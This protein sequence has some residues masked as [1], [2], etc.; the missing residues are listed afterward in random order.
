MGRLVEK[1]TSL[2]PFFLL[3]Q[4]FIR[5]SAIFS[6][7]PPHSLTPLSLYLLLFITWGE[8]WN[9]DCSLVPLMWVGPNLIIP[10]KEYASL[11]MR[12][13]ILELVLATENCSARQSPK[14]L[15]LSR[16]SQVLL[17]YQSTTVYPR[18]TW[19]VLV[20]WDYEQ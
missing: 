16:Y 15:W 7:I 12:T 17:A 2:S 10:G 19:G 5:C 9:H 8:W 20:H 6:V 3:Y 1:L 11:G 13:G 18:W 4:L 14:A